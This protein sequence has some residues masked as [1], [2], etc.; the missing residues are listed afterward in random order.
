MKKKAIENPEALEKQRI[1]V[2]RRFFEREDAGPIF[3]EGGTLRDHKRTAWRKNSGLF[4]E[5][6]C[7]L[8]LDHRI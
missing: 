7:G 6:L 8:Y 5:R 1:G 2:Q 4:L 3:K